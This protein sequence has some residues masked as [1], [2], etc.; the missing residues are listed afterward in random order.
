MAAMGEQTVTVAALSATPVKGLRIARRRS[1]RLERGRVVGD[2]VF[3]LIDQHGRMVNGKRAAGLQAVS[4]DYEEREQRLTLAFPDG[5]S[6]SE[7]IRLGEEL[8]TRFYSQERHARLVEGPLADALSEHTHLQLRLVA[9]ADGAYAADRGAEGAVSIISRGSLERLSAEAGQGEIDARRF[10][11]T[12][13]LAGPAAHE[14]DA[15][16]G[17]RLALGGA[18][19]ELVG[20]V[21]RCIVTTRNPESD[22]VD[23]PTLDL[24]RAY[25]GAGQ[26]TEPLAFGVYGAVLEP[27][28][29]SIGDEAVLEDR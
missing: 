14:E 1:L 2:R 15:W 22:E 13:E 25:R 27:G 28:A 18:T 26:T 4:A 9:P 16:V 10:R 5:T 29:V 17:R 19:V 24:L 11:M 3:Y 6:V 7:V 20:H 21:G 8:Q 23:L 12:V